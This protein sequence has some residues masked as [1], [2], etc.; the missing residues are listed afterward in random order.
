MAR[1]FARRVKGLA[2]SASC[3]IALWLGVCLKLS[4]QDR[5]D[6]VVFR[7]DPSRKGQ[8]A[9]LPRG[10]VLLFQV[11]QQLSSSTGQL[12]CFAAGD[13]PQT[14]IVLPRALEQL[15]FEAA[16]EI[17]EK[18]GYEISSETYKEKPA[19]WVSRPLVQPQRK[20]RIIRGAEGKTAQPPGESSKPAERSFLSAKV[21]F[22]ERQGGTG[23]RFL[24]VFQ[25][26]S[27]SEAEEILSVLEA[28]DR[29]RAKTQR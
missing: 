18:N 19:Y 4:T 11:L 2:W 5:G 3:L 21:S 10:E 16:R 8:S 7:P 24:V 29:A 25:S 9:S 23:G 6:P 22:Y 26:D 17:L 13:P 20:G 15:D 14:T 27:R 1:T 12:V 28:R